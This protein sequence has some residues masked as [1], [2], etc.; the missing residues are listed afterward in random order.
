MKYL[1]ALILLTSI[2]AFC[3]DQVPLKNLELQNGIQPFL[4]GTILSWPSSSLDR[5]QFSF[6]GYIFFTS[7]YGQY[8]PNWRLKKE[9]N[10]WNINQIYEC[11]Y[12]V[13][14]SIM[15]AFYLPIITN[16]SNGKSATHFQDAQL[17]LGFQIS[18]D[19]PN[20]W[21]PD[22]RLVFV[23]T[24]P[25]GKY[26]QLNPD[27]I[28]I[29]KTGEGAFQSGFTFVSAK[30]IVL[31]KHIL[32]LKGSLTYAYPFSV[33]VKGFHAYGGGNGTRGTAEPGQSINILISPQYSLTN[34]WSLALDSSLLFQAQSKFSGQKGVDAD[35][36]EATN[37]LPVSYQFSLFPQVEYNP[38][39]KM[40]LQWGVYFTCAG[41]NSPAFCSASFLYYINF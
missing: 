41:K 18:N 35:G 5:N 23:Q 17:T 9:S 26:N 39:P 36:S 30:S 4:P 24:F 16:F 2:P 33:K 31:G 12:G 13:T 3:R 20:S 27:K 7:V 1:I 10:L 21:I 32:N 11:Y 6:S 22:T 29:N 25:T 40:G 34:R 15:A 37:T 19:T 14:N 38:F 28:D 8:S